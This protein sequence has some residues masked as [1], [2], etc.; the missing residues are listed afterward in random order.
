MR[1]WRRRDCGRL[2]RASSYRSAYRFAAAR[3]LRNS[4]AVR[5]GPYPGVSRWMRQPFFE[6]S[7]VDRVE[8]ELVKQRA[9]R[10]LGVSVVAGND[11]RAAILR[12]R[13]PPVGGEL[14]GVDMVERL[15]DLRRRQVRLQELGRSRRLLVEFGNVSI[16]LR[17][18]IVC[19]DH[20]LPRK[21]LDRHLTIVLEW[22]RDHDNISSLRRVD[23]GRCAGVPSELVHEGGQGLR[24]ARVADHD[25]IALGDPKPR[26]LASNMSGSDE[27][28]GLHDKEYRS[29]SVRRR[30]TRRP[31]WTVS[32]LVA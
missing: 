9:D 21:R 19:V 5:R 28:D 27:S 17:I 12:A 14:R 23:G 4:S 16:P 29:Q 6:G 2:E 24:P 1:S 7:C 32:Y 26:N 30:A 25:V 13:R 18:V 20:N 15:D 11:E 22:H 31:T 10:G 8:A 3:S